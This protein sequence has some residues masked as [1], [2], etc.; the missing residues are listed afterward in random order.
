MGCNQIPVQVQE[1]SLTCQVHG[2]MA[3]LSSPLLYLPSFLPHLLSQPKQEGRPYEPGPFQGFSL[4]KGSSPFSMLLFFQ[5]LAW[6]TT[7]EV[8]LSK[9]WNLQMLRMLHAETFILS[10]SDLCSF[11]AFFSDFKQQNWCVSILLLCDSAAFFRLFLLNDLHF[12]TEHQKPQ[13]DVYVWNCLIQILVIIIKSVITTV[14]NVIITISSHIGNIT[15][16]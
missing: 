6:K 11:P 12:T 5:A 2:H 1:G 4:L 15:W 7:A 9:V 16:G 8:P 10:S 14:I 13:T 3:V